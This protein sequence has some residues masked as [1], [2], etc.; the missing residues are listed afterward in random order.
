M[1]SGGLFFVDVIKPSGWVLVFFSFAGPDEGEGIQIYHNTLLVGNDTIKTALSK[2]D[3]KR[4]I[5]IGRSFTEVDSINSYASVQVDELL[6]FN[7]AYDPQ[8]W[9]ELPDNI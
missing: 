9:I 5:V 3:G 8:G 2:T 7:K 1:L 6:F 4:K